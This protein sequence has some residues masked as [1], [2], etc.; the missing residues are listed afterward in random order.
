MQVTPLETFKQR[1]EAF[2]VSSGMAAARFGQEACGDRNF[3]FDL[4]KGEREFR[5]STLDRVRGFMDGFG[6]TSTP[7]NETGASKTAA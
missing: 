2:L 1:V 4:R 5:S 6:T 3:V 7:A